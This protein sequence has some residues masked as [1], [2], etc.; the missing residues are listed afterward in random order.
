MT[1]M[2]RALGAVQLASTALL[3]VPASAQDGPQIEERERGY[4]RGDSVRE[5]RREQAREGRAAQASNDWA[6]QARAAQQARA[7][8]REAQREAADAQRDAA[9]AQ[10]D[11]WAAQAQGRE[12]RRDAAEAQR[13]AW[14]QRQRRDNSTVVPGGRGAGFDPEDWHDVA[15]ERQAAADAARADRE[16][17]REAA[18]RE[19]LERERDRSYGADRDGRYRDDRRDG[20]YRDGYHRDDWRY[21]NDWGRY[22]DRYGRYDRWDRFG[23]RNDRRYDWHRYRQSNRDIFRLGRYYAPVYNYRYSRI[24]LGFHLGRSF[25]TDRYWINDPWRYRLPQVYGPYR[26]VRYYDDVLLVDLR[27]GQVVDVIYN[28]FW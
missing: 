10:R 16:R 27:S 9:R 3:T 24:G 13:E 12:A 23:W 21:R 5:Q 6:E 28:F 17:E 11:A 20:R 25:Y 4:G 8:A 14:A 7:Q 26:W 15:R 19:R 1:K 22:D 18:V 2:T